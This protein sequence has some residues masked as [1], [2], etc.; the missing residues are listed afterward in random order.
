VPRH[1]LKDISLWLFRVTQEALYNTVNY[2]GVNEFSVQ[3]S[4]TADEIQLVVQDA[5]A[6]FDMEDAKKSRGFGLVSM[7]ERV[8]LVSGSFSVESKPV[9]GTKILVAVPL[10]LENASPPEAKAVQSKSLTG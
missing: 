5:G 10:V 6:G 7:Q 3:I 8:H 4:G 9:R 2:S 1:L